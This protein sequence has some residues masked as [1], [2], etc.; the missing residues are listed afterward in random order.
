MMVERSINIIAKLIISHLFFGHIEAGNSRNR[1][2][3]GSLRLL[4]GPLHMDWFGRLDTSCSVDDF[5]CLINNP[6][7]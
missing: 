3:L 6:L 1:D 5:I 4:F 2:L 7:P